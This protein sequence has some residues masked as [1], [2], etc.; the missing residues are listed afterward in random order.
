MLNGYYQAKKINYRM[1]LVF[2]FLMSQIYPCMLL[3]TL[4]DFK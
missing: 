4:Q 3:K 1:H 2:I